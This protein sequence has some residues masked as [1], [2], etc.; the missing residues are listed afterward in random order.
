MSLLMYLPALWQVPPFVFCIMLV[1]CLVLLVREYIHYCAHQKYF[2][3]SFNAYLQYRFGHW[4]SW[5]PGAPGIFLGML[6]LG[7]IF[8]GGGLLS[9]STG[10]E[11]PDSLWMAWVWTAAPDGGSSAETLEARTVGVFMSCGGLLL[12]ALLTSMVSAELEKRLFSLREGRY[13]VVEHGHV[14]ILGWSQVLLV[15]IE[16]LSIAAEGRGGCTIAVLTPRAKQEMEA[17]IQDSSL[18]LRGSRLV[19]R[20]GDARKPDDLEKVAVQAAMVVVILS[21]METSREDADARSLHVLMTLVSNK[22]PSHGSLVVQ[23]GLV[24]NNRLFKRICPDEAEVMTTTD[25]VGKLIVQSSREQGLATVLCTIIGFEDSEFYV[26]RV[27]GTAGLRF[28]DVLFAIP[29]MIPVGLELPDGH[30]MML[31]AMDCTLDGTERLVLLAQDASTLPKLAFGKFLTRITE[32]HQSLEQPEGG[33]KRVSSFE[34]TKEIVVII[35]WNEAI[36]SLMVELDRTVGRGSEVFIY[37]P[38]ASQERI[39]FLEA[40][41]K[42]RC[43]HYRNLIA[44]HREGE[45]GARFRLEELPLARASKL[46]ILADDC[47]CAMTEVDSATIAVILQVHDILADLTDRGV[48]KVPPIL[49]SQILDSETE[50]HCR[51]AGLGNIVVSNALV[52][53]VLATACCSGAFGSARLGILSE[54]ISE[55]PGCHLCIRQLTDYP[56]FSGSMLAASAAQAGLAFDEVAFVASLADEIALGWT[57]VGG[58][59]AGPWEINPKSRSLRRAWDVNA[60]L[61]VLAPHRENEDVRRR[62]SEEALGN[63]SKRRCL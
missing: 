8:L 5:T 55:S 43:H 53:R 52:G 2:S 22:W 50:T 26:H 62:P 25:F 60:R 35:G 32:L 9:I 7:L 1:L 14:V 56:Y 44:I 11:L 57:A 47:K 15:L 13:P 51:H 33:F 12:F 37:S 45:L 6:C 28:R 19:F 23:C 58:S 39:E 10:Q 49:L 34:V 42:R 21:D 31:P 27:T 41:Q 48:I 40:A 18:D 17:G 29:D 54:V 38:R 3:A 20:S 61:V 24:R 46:L 36:E 59:P 4:Y 63:E 16:Q 30:I